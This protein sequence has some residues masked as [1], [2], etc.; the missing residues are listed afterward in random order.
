MTTFFSDFK[1]IMQFFDM[2]GG[3]A[4]P[5][6]VKNGPFLDH[7]WTTF[8]RGGKFDLGKRGKMSRGGKRVLKRVSKKWYFR[9][10]RGSGGLGR[11]PGGVQKWSKNGSK[12][13]LDLRPPLSRCCPVLGIKLVKRGQKGGQKW[14][15]KGVKKGVPLEEGSFCPLRRKMRNFGQTGSVLS[16][17]DKK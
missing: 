12:S 15:K 8:S 3:S 7:F 10:S 1:Q 9:D 2:P 14:P 13:G 5:E 17:T 16:K 4:T 6:N 11:G